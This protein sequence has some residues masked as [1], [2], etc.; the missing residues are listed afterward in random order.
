[1]LDRCFRRGKQQE[2][3]LLVVRVDASAR[4]FTCGVNCVFLLVGVL[5]PS[6][7]SL[8]FACFGLRRFPKELE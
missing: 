3:T 5:V 6:N 2:D 8:V 7:K 1:M 4:S